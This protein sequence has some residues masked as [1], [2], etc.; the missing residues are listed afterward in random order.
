[1][2]GAILFS[3]TIQ[4]SVAADPYAVS[5][6]RRSGFRPKRSWVGPIIVFTAPTSAWR[7]SR[8]AS[9]VHNHLKLHIDE[10]VI[11]VGEKGRSAYRPRPLGGRIR[12][13]VELRPDLARRAKGS[14]IEGCKILFHRAACG[15]LL[16]P[17][18]SRDRTLLVGVRHDQAGIDGK[19]FA[20]DQPCRNARFH[21]MLEDTAQN[22]TVTEPLIA[23]ARERRV[24]RDSI[25]IH[26][27]SDRPG[28]LAHPG[29]A[30]NRGCIIRTNNPAFRRTRFQTRRQSRPLRATRKVRLCPIE[31]RQTTSP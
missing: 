16:V 23:G 26:R 15:T 1:M 10:I 9:T 17:L 8:V 7:M 29:T 19:P 28:S 12:R 24:I 31:E 5:A 3:L 22:V 30:A 4:L 18:G 13:R 21:D 11:G 25:E 14:L 20:A 27:T 6:A 2:C